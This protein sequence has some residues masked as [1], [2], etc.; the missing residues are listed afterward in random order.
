MSSIPLALCHHGKSQGQGKN[1]LLSRSIAESFPGVKNTQVIDVLDIAL[2]KVQCRTVFLGDKVQR[3]QCLR[4]CLG[5]RW[6][7]GGPRLCE[8][9]CEVTTGV[10]NHNPFRGGCSGRFMVQNGTV[11]VWLFGIEPICSKLVSPRRLF[12]MEKAEERP[13]TYP[14]TGQSCDSVWI[15]SGRSLARML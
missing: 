7:I 13:S 15:K 11:C 4:L 8:E 14:S 10:L 9:P 5:D 2:L 3:V 6:N 12:S 1:V